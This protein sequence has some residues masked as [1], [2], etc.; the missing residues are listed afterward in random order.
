[1]SRLSRFIDIARIRFIQIQ[2]S[3]L[4]FNQIHIQMKKLCFTALIAALILLCTQGIQPP[5]LQAQ[6]AQ[7]QSPAVSLGVRDN[8]DSKVLNEQRRILVY[9]PASASSEIYTRQ[10]YPV[11]YLLD[12]DVV[13]FS[14]VVSMI[15]Q[16]SSLFALPEMMVVGIPNTDRTRDLTP[17]PMDDYW[18]FL[19]FEADS[20]F[21]KNSGGGKN[22]MSFIET[23]LIPHINSKYPA[24]P[25]RM[26][27]GHSLGGLT[28]MNTLIHHTHLFNDYV[29]IDPAMSWD[30]QKLLQE[31]KT[32][33]ANNKYPGISL[34]LAIANTM[35]DG[36]DTT[37][38]K[39]ESTGSSEH[40]RS[41]FKLRDYLSSNGG[42]QLNFAY[43]YYKNE[44]HNS[45]RL[46]AEYDAFR[47]FFNY[48]G[49]SLFYEDY[50]NLENLYD[51]LS[52]HFGY[53][54]KPP[55][56]MV[57]ILAYNY[58]FHN[59]FDE[60]GYLFNLNVTNYPDSYN[61]YDAMGDY[62][63]KKGETPNAIESYTKAL[64]IKEVLAVR[65][66]LDKIQ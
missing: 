24:A 12:G 59:K 26:L 9:V 18:Q 5:T 61:V 49:L 40:I 8:I 20:I 39:K 64:S 46:I 52:R 6:S 54:V 19:D 37:R 41:I 53:T 51:N 31:T 30:N 23:E 22:F 45:V 16:L 32:A 34:F 27:I 3:F 13:H 10:L 55:E 57:N 66:K 17:T 36:M 28:V 4:V 48:Y 25:Y 1:M 56:R 65:Q 35:E 33:L 29:A 38:V 50:R 7:T 58:L 14:A 43:K 2:L 44:E 21:L 15:N 47:Y 11:V 62:F 60:A 63:S 42:N